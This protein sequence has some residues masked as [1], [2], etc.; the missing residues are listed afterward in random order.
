MVT[1]WYDIMETIRS[2]LTEVEV[3]L[4]EIEGL[5]ESSPGVKS[6]LSRCIGILNSTLEVVANAPAPKV[7]V[8]RP[9]N[10]P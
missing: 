2:G 5:P 3:T 9:A 10:K 7:T 6:V 1:S 4:T 8:V